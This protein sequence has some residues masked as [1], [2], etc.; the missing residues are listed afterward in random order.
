MP[1]RRLDAG[2]TPKVSNIG[3]AAMGSAH[4]L[5]P[6]ATT[7]DAQGYSGDAVQPNQNNPPESMIPPTT[8]GARRAS[9][10]ALPLFFLTADLYRGWLARFINDDNCTPTKIPKKG[11]VD[12]NKL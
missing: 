2:A 5:L 8:M 1:P 10:T 7:G 3:W 9:G 4:E 12:R 11:K 6:A